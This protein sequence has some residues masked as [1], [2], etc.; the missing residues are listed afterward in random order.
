MDII[1]LLKT[2]YS[3]KEFDSTKEITEEDLKIIE[4]ILQLS[5]SSTNIQP[6]KFIIANTTEGKK[7]I[8]KA[9]TGFYSFNEEKILNSSITIVFASLVD[10]S[11]EYLNKVL[12]KEDKDG[13]YIT[14]ELK[15]QGHDARSIFSKMHKFEYKDFQHWTDKQLYLNL[16][17]FLLGVSSLGLDAI[18]MEGIDLKLL[19]QEFGLKE[20]GYTSSFVV[21]VG[22]SKE[23]D[24]NKKLPKSRLDKKEIIRR[25]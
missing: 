9:T 12:E 24:Y 23:T 19:D 20:E 16:G 4:D 13:R 25:V 17:N 10:L 22:Y 14:E 7:R 15:Q 11:D 5:P 1:N 2:R 3:A 18:A 21:S 6:W 8:T